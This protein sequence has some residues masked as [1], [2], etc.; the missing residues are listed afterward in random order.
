MIKKIVGHPD[1]R[2][3]EEL[4][5][6][7]GHAFLDVIAWS[8]VHVANPAARHVMPA[9]HRRQT[10]RIDS[11]LR[12]PKEDRKSVNVDETVDLGYT[13]LVS[14]SDESSEHRLHDPSEHQPS[15]P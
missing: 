3:A 5:R 7:P 15:A 8:C 10:E 6:K 1:A 2:F 14:R 9:R 4:C 12:L 13:A 11:K